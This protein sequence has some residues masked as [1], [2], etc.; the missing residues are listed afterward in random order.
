[1]EEGKVIF[2]NKKIV[3]RYPNK[4]DAKPMQDYINVLSLEKTF[5]R[6][7]G[8]QQSFEEEQKY[9]DGLLTKISKNNA[10]VLLA[11]SGNKL[12]ANSQIDMKDKT[13]KHIG[14]FGISVAKENRG[15]GIGKILMENVLKEAEKNISELKIIILSVY[16]NNSLAQNM[17]K[18]FGFSEYG[19]LPKG[20]CRK[21]DYEDEILLYKEV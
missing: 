2:Q 17:Y 16:A 9:L 21:G 6:Y 5:I 10:V 13:E 1:M 18:K 15:K 7:Q 19:R 12:I 14:V 4:Y 11:F 20:I 3:I 8:E